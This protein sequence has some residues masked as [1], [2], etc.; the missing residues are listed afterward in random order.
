MRRLVDFQI[1]LSGA[2]LYEEQPVNED[3]F[4]IYEPVR[5]WLRSADLRAPFRKLVI[6]FVSTPDAH[7]LVANAVDVCSAYLMVDRSEL[8][9][10]RTN[11]GWVLGHVVQALGNVHRKLG[12]SSAELLTVLEGMARQGFPLR[13][14]L[15]R[16]HR[17]NQQGLRGVPWVSFEPNRAELWLTI[18]GPGVPPQQIMVRHFAR[19]LMMEDEFDLDDCASRWTRTSFDF[20]ARDGSV[21]ATVPLP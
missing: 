11:P 9:Q 13:A 7:G 3:L 10:S 2:P 19:P 1:S 4:S 6:C 18:E 12:W 20:V 15:P 5:L 21:L 16:L 17:R 14:E 8:T